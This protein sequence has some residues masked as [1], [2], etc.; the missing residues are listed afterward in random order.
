M[1]RLRV[2]LSFDSSW[3]EGSGVTRT[4]RGIDVLVF[5]EL[6]DGGYA[7]LEA[8]RGSHTMG[9][10]FLERFRRLT[11]SISL[12]CVAGSVLLRGRGGAKTNSVLVYQS[13]KLIHRYDKIH[14]FRPT[15]DARFFDPGGAL[16]GFTFSAAGTTV[17]AGVVICY[18]LRFPELI[19]A[20][21]KEGIDV[22]F[23]P[24]RWPRVRDAAWRTLLRARAMENQVFVVGCDARG[25]EGGHSY[26]FDPFGREIFSTRR[27][28]ASRLQRCDVDLDRIA[29]ARKHHF[30]LREARL[31]G[32]IRFP[33]RVRKVP[34]KS[35]AALSRKSAGG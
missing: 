17:K 7:A 10:P 18:D 5:P 20:L 33:R 23:V 22:L 35:G 30:N 26:V 31:L 12:A 9:D 4:L 32:S 24:A 6:V 2:G 25:S 1:R 13:G 3:L 14:L 21:A 29:E 19:R 34:V 16:G 15:G 11:G 28:K 8:G 27:L